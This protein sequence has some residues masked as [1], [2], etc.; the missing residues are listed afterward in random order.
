MRSLDNKSLSE[1]NN[2]IIEIDDILTEFIDD[3]LLIAPQSLK[4][5]NAR[6]YQINPYQSNTIDLV[7]MIAGRLKKFKIKNYQFTESMT[8]LV[9]FDDDIRFF[10]KNMLSECSIVLSG[11]KKSWVKQ[12]IPFVVYNKSVKVPFIKECFINKIIKK[13]K[14]NNDVA[15][16]IVFAVLRELIPS[17]IDATKEYY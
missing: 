14:M 7:D 6:L 3:G 9:I 2:S 5:E 13:Y 11:N 4:Y 1:S 16:L 15:K 8:F 10:V 12:T 17:S